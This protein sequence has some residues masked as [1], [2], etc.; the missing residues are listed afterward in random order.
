[1]DITQIEAAANAAHFAHRFIPGTYRPPGNSVQPARIDIDRSAQVLDARGIVMEDR[2]EISL[3]VAEVGE[4]ERGAKVAAAAFPGEVWILLEPI[5][6][7]GAESRWV[8][9]RD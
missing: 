7:D 3:I 8:A 6:N 5:G 2:C 4:G 1:M 9:T